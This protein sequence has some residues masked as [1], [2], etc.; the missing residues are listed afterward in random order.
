MGF[1][2]LTHKRKKKLIILEDYQ[3]IHHIIFF[4]I[5]SNMRSSFS[6]SNSIGIFFTIHFCFILKKKVFG[7]EDLK[8]SSTK[9][10]LE[11]QGIIYYKI[12]QLD[13]NKSRIKRHITKQL[14]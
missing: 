7:R 8:I 5:T 4:E 3:K 1:L 12:V 14:K 6:N 11:P 2:Q 10:N 13:N 9:F